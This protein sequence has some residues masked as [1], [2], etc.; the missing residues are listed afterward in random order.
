MKLSGKKSELVGRICEEI[1][2]INKLK[3]SNPESII[4]QFMKFTGREGVWKIYLLHIIR[5]DY[6]PIFDQ[7]TYRA[8]QYIKTGLIREISEIHEDMF[9]FYL[10]IYLPF[11]HSK[12]DSI[13]TVK[14][15]INKIGK[16]DRALF[17]FGK[18]LNSN[19]ARLLGPALDFKFFKT[20]FSSVY[21]INKNDYSPD[22]KYY[23]CKNPEQEAIVEK[24]LNERDNYMKNAN[25][26][27]RWEMGYFLMENFKI[28]FEQSEGSELI[29]SLCCAI[30]DEYSLSKQEV[31][32]L[33]NEIDHLQKV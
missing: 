32:Q 24:L 29:F 17:T 2:L 3:E 22:L 1:D 8:Y 18:F 15:K 26:N 16:I 30:K 20:L 25:Y 27:L 31:G 19:F 7:H 23:L 28:K 12:F 11:I 9:D 33:F 6:Y 4:P 21:A 5:P 14:E 13:L 10:Q